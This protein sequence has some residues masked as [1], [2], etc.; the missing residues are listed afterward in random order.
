[1]N[2]TSFHNAMME[3]FPEAANGDWSPEFIRLVKANEEAKAVKLLEREDYAP[4]EYAMEIITDDWWRAKEPIIRL[5]SKH[6]DFDWGI[7]GVRIP[8]NFTS[9]KLDTDALW[10]F[11]SFLDREIWRDYL[12]GLAIDIDKRNDIYTFFGKIDSQFLDSRFDEIIEKLNKWNPDYH[13]R[14]NMKSSKAILKICREEGWDKMGPTYIDYNGNEKLQFDRLYAA[15]ADC[16]NPLT[17]EYNSYFSVGMAD[18]WSM[19]IGKNWHSCHCIEYPDNPGCYSAGCTSYLLDDC[20]IVYWDIDPDE[21][22]DDYPCYIKKMRRQMFAYKNGAFM[23]S[24]LYPQSMDYGAED[25]YRHIR[26]LVQKIL[27]DCLGEPNLWDA[28][29]RNLGIINDHV[30]TTGVNYPDWHEG[31]PGSQHCLLSK[32]KSR[33]GY[34]YMIFGVEPI[35]IECGNTF[36]DEENISCCI[37]GHR[38]ACAGCGDY[39]DEDDLHWCEDTRDYRCNDC[40]DWD[41]I[42]EEYF[43]GERYYVYTRDYY[44]DTVER[45]ISEDTY[46]NYCSVCDL[47]DTTWVSDDMTEID[48]E[49]ICPDC[50]DNSTESCEGCGAL[51]LRKNMTRIEDKWYDDECLADLEEKLEEREVG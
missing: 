22:R 5:L 40:C 18:Y 34:P 30:T 33:E 4:T 8:H 25:A 37:N 6:P 39:Y 50:M 49:W 38:C 19:S 24:R 26:E 13:L 29:E 27:A 43:G 35:C 14:N 16:L 51:H 36:R 42:R 9:R 44:G 28:P 47:C 3:R 11:Y 41:E 1:M 21:D 10:D 31:N 48:G 32:L 23:Q 17:V 45:T 12:G 20:A 15:L 7:C 2:K 46:D